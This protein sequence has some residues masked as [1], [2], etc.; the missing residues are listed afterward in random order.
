MIVFD[1]CCTTG[2]VFEAW[3]ASSE[4]YE[5]QR[6]KGLVGCPVCGAT[7][8]D[9]A[10]MA[11]RV[12]PKGNQR[13]EAKAAYEALARAQAEALKDSHWVGDGFAEAARAIHLGEAEARAIHGQASI[14]EARALHEEGVPVLPLPLPIRPPRTDN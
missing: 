9:K 7:E 1:L 10:V 11:P 3:F 6:A 14:D 5:E 4:A 12:G 13:A 2:H 8:I